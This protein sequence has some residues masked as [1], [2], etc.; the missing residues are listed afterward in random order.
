MKKLLALRNLDIDLTKSETR[1]LLGFSLLYS[2]LVLVILCV[3]FFLYYQFQKDLMLQEKRQILQT[4]SNSLISNLKEL[5]I[6]I[7]K[8]NIYPRDEKYKSAIYDSDKKKIFSTLQSQTVK[9]DDVIYLKNDKIHFIKEPESYYLGSKYVIVEIPDD[10]IWFEN[11]KYKMIVGFL[12]A[13]LFMIF[14]GYF[15]SKLFLKPMRDA[16]HLL[17]RFIKDT[18]HELNTP[19][20]AI[21]TN[22]ETIDK[23]LLDDKTLRKINRIEIGAKTISNIYEDLTF[24]T[25]NNQ[26]ISNNEN[27]NLSNIV[28][29]RVDFFL[30]IANMKKIRFETNIKDNV[31]IFCDVKKISKLIDNLLSNAIKYNKNSGFIKVI[32]AKNSMIIEDSGKG[33]SSENLENLFDRYQRFDKS[34]GGF[35]IGL[36]IV[37]LIAKEYD[38]KIDVTSQLGVGT[39]VKI[40]W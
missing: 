14:V 37:S 10:H 21:I 25:L 30:S 38:F 5:H 26:I 4:Y 22:I 24:V 33:M 31:F 9:L 17:D 18:T 16:L 11:I 12:L 7:D 13:F 8:D 28:R 29:Q 39:K 20:T 3:M 19:V 34:V 2:F 23:S 40:R 35:G 6:N 32:L 36:N 15:I 1:T 27:I